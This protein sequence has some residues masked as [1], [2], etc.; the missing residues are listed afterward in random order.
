MNMGEAERGSRRK[1]NN[2]PR[3]KRERASWYSHEGA[4]RDLG[5]KS[6]EKMMMLKN[7]K[8]QRNM[9]FGILKKI[10]NKNFTPFF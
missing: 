4:K 9:N 6:E 10:T 3:G 5:G 1:V 8:E 2:E 7:D